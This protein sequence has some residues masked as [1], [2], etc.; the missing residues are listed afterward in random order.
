M[1]I[2]VI[3]PVHNAEKTI[4]KTLA[5]IKNQQGTDLDIEIIAVDDG[6]TD[7]TPA[8]LSSHKNIVV[9][10][11][12]N[13]GPASARN[14]GG[15]VAT[16]DILVFTDSDTIPHP[17]WIKELTSP[18]NDEAIMVTAGTYT[19]A[20]SGNRLAE[21]IQREIE[22]R[23][24]GYG[25]FVE[26]GGTYNLALRKCLFISIGGFDESY[27]RASGEDNDFCYRILR[28]GYKIRYVPTA[29]VAHHHPEF[30][31]K[32]MKEQFR[33]G[34]WRAKLYLEHPG[35]LSGDSYT[36]YKDILET[37]TCMALIC[38]PL[39]RIFSKL[40]PCFAG[41]IISS[42]ACWAIILVL[43]EFF[44]AIRMTK[45]PTRLVFIDL[46][47]SCR[48]LSRTAGFIA[49]LLCFGSRRLLAGYSVGCA[50][51]AKS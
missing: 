10:T 39:T 51:G 41:R 48:A 47:F 13:A 42:T 22:L 34:F 14:S 6:S 26:F 3:V 44:T 29:K 23:H 37:V 19:I 18:F 43:T 21:A 5:A 38:S 9:L 17:D 4:Q 33:H 46:V 45:E 16:G 31:S 11:Q 12:K 27:R 24:A 15:K 28:Q 50:D 35:Q 1:K 8:I 32:Y 25:K 2:S 7:G 20:N 36:G 49:G 30:F 40:R